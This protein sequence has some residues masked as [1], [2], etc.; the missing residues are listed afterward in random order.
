MIKRNDLAKQFELVVQQEIK[1]HNDQMLATNLAVNEIRQKMEDEKIRTDRIDAHYGDR[2]SS[3]NHFRQYIQLNLNNLIQYV[4]NHINDQKTLHEKNLK[5]FFDLGEDILELYKAEDKTSSYFNTLS[6]SINEIKENVNKHFRDIKLRF[7][8]LDKQY[9]V[10]LQKTKE[11]IL[12]LPSEAKAV[13]KELEEKMAIDRVDFQGL[14]KELRVYKREN[15][16]QQKEIEKL[17]ILID[18]LEKRI[19][20]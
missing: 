1:N 20:S 13:K 6:I 15:L 8:E 9:S 18:R 5:R 12:S 7:D 2:I 10:K 3:L 16:I 4:E 11:D 14:L 17:Y 19:K